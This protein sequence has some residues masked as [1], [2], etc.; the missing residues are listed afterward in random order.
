MKK[1][2]IT[3]VCI[4][5]FS[6]VGVAQNLDKL[7]KKAAK[8]ENVDSFK[9]DGLVLWLG[10]MFGAASELPSSLKSISKIEIHDLSTSDEKLKLEVNEEIK[11]L[12]SS[13]NYETLSH[14]KNKGENIKVLLR[15]EKKSIREFLVL[16]SK[17]NSPKIIRIFGNI[18]EKDLA[19]LMN[20]YDSQ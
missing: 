20:K 1:L 2:F 4:T 11:S 14:I 16:V 6:Q 19:T 13:G 7:L 10:K 3:I 18:D 9:V 15:K 17:D 12:N 8:A 5:L